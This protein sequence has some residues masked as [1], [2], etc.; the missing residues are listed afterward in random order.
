MQCLT[1]MVG[2]NFMITDPQPIYTKDCNYIL[3]QPQELPNELLQITPSEGVEIGG[4]LA[5]VLLAGFT[6]RAIAKAL[7]ASDRSNENE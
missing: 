5:L 7:N 3:V 4:K 2:G 6:F 1:Q